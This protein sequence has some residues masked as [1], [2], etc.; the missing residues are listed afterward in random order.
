M[1]RIGGLLLVILGLAVAAFGIF[2]AV[3]A[4]DSTVVTVTV[5]GGDSQ[6]IYTAPGVLAL[7]NDSVD[8]KL[9]AS[10][11]SVQWAVA[12]TKDVEAYVGE[13]PALKVTGLTSWEEF[14]TE[15][16]P[17]TA[18]GRKAI[19]DAVANSSFDLTASDMWLDAGAGEGSVETTLTADH[20]VEQSLIATTSKGVAPTLTLSW[21]HSRTVANPMPIIA[22]GVLLILISALM[23][24]SARQEAALSKGIAGAYRERRERSEA[25]TSIFPKV[26]EREDVEMSTRS[27]YG[28]SILPA[29]NL[30]LRNREL[31]E[32]DRVVLPVEEATDLAKTTEA[33]QAESATPQE[34]SAQAAIDGGEP[35][36]LGKVDAGQPESQP[37]ADVSA[38]EDAGSQEPGEQDWRS[39]WNFSWGTPWQKGENNA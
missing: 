24:L 14:A 29:A 27:A 38:S 17:G 31:S 8:V 35:D 26:G 3:T 2:Q 16:L 15:V 37:G 23:L 13:A 19:D 32:E 20:A 33:E 21:Q 25:Q 5:P 34:G 9:T 11:G 1:K 18:D 30:D 22:I 7:V 36:D 28:A 39:L 6:F 12:S 10:E 4:E